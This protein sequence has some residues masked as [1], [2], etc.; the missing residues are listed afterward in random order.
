MK[1]FGVDGWGVFA[2]G[3]SFLVVFGSGLFVLPYRYFSF[4]LSLS[5]LLMCSFG[6]CSGGILL[7]FLAHRLY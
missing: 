7:G 6:E 3:V 4:L 5:F 2:L 1:V